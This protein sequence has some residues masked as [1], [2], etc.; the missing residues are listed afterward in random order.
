[1]NLI[2]ISAL[3]AAFPAPQPP[4]G[5][6]SHSYGF[7][8]DTANLTSLAEWDFTNGSLTPQVIG[9]EVTGGGNGY[10]GVMYN[11]SS[12][13]PDAQYA[14]LVCTLTGNGGN[15]VIVCAGSGQG[16]A[17]EVNNTASAVR[18]LKIT[19]TGALSTTVMVVE[20]P[21]VPA[22]PFTIRLERSGD[23]LT[24]YVNGTAVISATDADYT[25]GKAGVWLWRPNWRGDSFTCGAL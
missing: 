6:V 8:T 3:A 17:L 9:G 10:A 16:Y 20:V 12:D 18:L 19:G 5:G 1:M 11:P 25:G 7:P 24:G 23:L 15:G 2:S 13:L 21:I 22:T 14:Q 4:A